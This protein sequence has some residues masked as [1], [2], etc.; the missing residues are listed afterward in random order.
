MIYVRF[1][2]FLQSSLEYVSK[3]KTLRCFIEYLTCRYIN[4]FFI[5]AANFKRFQSSVIAWWNRFSKA[6]L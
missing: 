5:F 4:T 3:K 6:I 2:A 1:Q